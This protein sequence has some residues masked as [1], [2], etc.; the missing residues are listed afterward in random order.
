MARAAA[1][2]LLLLGLLPLANWIPGG[3]E[4]PWYG[5]RLAL[6]GSGGA[7]IAGITLVAAIVLRRRPAQRVLTPHKPALPPP[8]VLLPAVAAGWAAGLAPALLAAGIDTFADL[9]E[10]I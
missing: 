9:D 7:I 5:Q 3:H 4:A 1:L 2:V 10:T 6:W 8:A